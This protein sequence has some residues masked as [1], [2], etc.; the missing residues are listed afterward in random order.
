MPFFGSRHNSEDLSTNV[1]EF[2]HTKSNLSDE[3]M[4]SVRTVSGESS[5]LPFPLCSAELVQAGGEEPTFKEPL[6]LFQQPLSLQTIADLSEEDNRSLE[7]V[8]DK[9]FHWV[10]VPSENLDSIADI[11]LMRALHHRNEVS[12]QAAAQRSRSPAEAAQLTACG[13]DSRVGIGKPPSGSLRG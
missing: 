5:P 10:D 7:Q 2:T 9:V 1:L 12:R 6:S 3:D 8:R 13:V 4:M 11:D